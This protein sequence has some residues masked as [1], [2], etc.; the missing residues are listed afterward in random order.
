MTMNPQPK[1]ERPPEREMLGRYEVV[2]LIATGGMA[3]VYLALHGELAGFRTPVVLKK[4]RPHLASD[5]RFIDMFL[6]EARIAAL[7]DHPNVVKMIEVGKAGSGYF[8]AMELVQGNCFAE[9]LRRHYQEAFTQ[10]AGPT[11]CGFDG[12]LAAFIG[13]QVAAG[14]HHAHDLTNP[15]GT[16]LGL[17]H[18]DVSPENILVSFEGAVKLIDFGIAQAWGKLNQTQTGYVKGKFRYMSPEQARGETIDR[19][20]DIF[21]LGIVLWEAL[22][23]RRLFD[24]DNSLAA[25]HAL[26]EG[27]IPP[28][29]RMVPVAPELEAIVMRALERRPERR[30]QS[31]REMGGALDAYLR[32]S[33]GANGSDLAVVM[34]AFFARDQGSWQQAV[35][36]AVH[37]PGAPEKDLTFHATTPVGLTAVRLPHKPRRW[38]AAG[39]VV[40]G[41]ALAGFGWRAWRGLPRPA[42]AS[43]AAAPVST[44]LPAQTTSSGEPLPMAA[45]MPAP[46]M[47]FAE[48]LFPPEKAQPRRERPE[49][50]ETASRKERRPRSKSPA[51]EPAPRSS[52]RPR[53][54]VTSGDRPPPP[55]VERLAPRPGIERWDDPTPVVTSRKRPNPFAG[56]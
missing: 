19:R 44:S 5:S 48:P 35:R 21:S 41:C 24:G 12:R 15:F 29:S 42:P 32:A 33:G 10:G 20:T 14:L 3:E 6:D 56:P 54:A 43:A 22:T 52:A 4:V 30:Y 25:M 16:P 46:L 18:R 7:L 13:A 36:S 38:L 31:A 53:P 50:R 28:V 37:L 39:A 27:P 55:P 1:A 49:A 8:L 26:I 9:L 11:G 34:K 47:D 40:L 51:A 45:E 23:G 17:V 2:D